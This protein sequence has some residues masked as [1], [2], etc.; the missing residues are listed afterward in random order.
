[1]HKKAHS[2]SN[3]KTNGRARPDLPMSTEWV[4]GWSG[5]PL[6]RVQEG[7]GPSHRLVTEHERQ[8]H[9][10]RYS[11]IIPGEHPL[12]RKLKLFNRCLV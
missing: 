7:Y 5:G 10:A 9:K 8:K 1:M 2:Y 4:Q 6:G 11:R 12:S 3:W